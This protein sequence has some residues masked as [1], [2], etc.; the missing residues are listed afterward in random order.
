MERC[1]FAWRVR[2]SA[3]SSPSP[4]FP[5]AAAQWLAPWQAASPGE[6]ERSLEAQG[7]GL[8]APLVR[9]PGIYLADVSAGPAGHQRLVI[10]ARSGQILE[11]FIAPGRMWGPALAARDEE[12]GEPRPPGA[13]PPLKSRLR[14]AAR[15]RRGG[16]IGLRRSSERPYSGS[17]QSVWR[18]GSAG[19]NEAQAEVR[20]DRTQGAGDQTRINPAS[21]ASGATRSGD[22]GRIGLASVQAGGEA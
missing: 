10:D 7:Y 15:G 22:V 12:F 14:R 20:F 2:R 5:T 1:A 4:S 3:D 11:R 21:A 9:R 13:E 19:R 16:E 6:I 17:H 8:I 18:W